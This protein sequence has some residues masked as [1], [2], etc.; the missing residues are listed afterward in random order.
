MSPRRAALRRCR[1][2]PPGHLASVASGP[3]PLFGDAPPPAAISVLDLARLTLISFLSV[4]YALSWGTH[5]NDSFSRTTTAPLALRAF[6]P[7]LRCHAAA[8]SGHQYRVPSSFFVAYANS[9]GPLSSGCPSFAPFAP[10]FLRIADR[11]SS[12]HLPRH[13]AVCSGSLYRVPSS[14]FAAPPFASVGP[15]FLRI[16]DRAP[17]PRL[18]RHAAVSFGCQFRVPS[19]FLVA[20]ANSWGP[21]SS[22][23]PPLAPVGP[24][25]L[26]T[27]DRASRTTTT[28]PLALCASSPRPCRHA[29]VSSGPQYR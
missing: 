15:L 3:V 13:A 16:T 29:A 10:L 27:T 24:L 11:A 28:A 4:G 17:S 5:F 2:D 20:Y 9:W 19:P 12:P 21:L 1:S 7:H 6:S 25:F 14:F 23:C 26:R 8:F 18:R 22:G